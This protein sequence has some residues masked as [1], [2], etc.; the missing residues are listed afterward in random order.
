MSSAG[1]TKSFSSGRV[2]FDPH[3]NYM[4]PEPYASMYN[5]REVTVPEFRDGEFDDKPPH[6]RMTQEID[7]DFSAYTKDKGGNWLHGAQS[8]LR[9]KE[10]KAKNIAAMYGMVTMMDSYIGRI[11]DHL[12]DLGLTRDTLVVFTSDHGDFYGQHGL[13]AK[14]LH[15]Y[16]D[17]I[18]VPAVVSL[19]GEIPEGAVCRNIQSTV[20]LAPTFLSFAGLPIPGRMSGIDV[21]G[22]WK[23]EVSNMRKHAIVENHHNPT[24]FHAE[25]MVTEKY[26]ITVYRM[27]EYG[28]LFDLES[29]PNEYVNLWD[30]PEFLA[31]KQKLLLEFVQAKMETEQ[32]PMPRI[33]GA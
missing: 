18:R 5:P 22:S 28:E 21:S 19:P 13:V 2:F 9:S 33:A 25:T 4:V 29:D 8:H 30:N 1:K 10:E 20:D 17:L 23:G 11:L 26:K 6:F 32:I 3:P 16:E 15:H 7:P 14:A 24:S 31:V 27:A 12:D